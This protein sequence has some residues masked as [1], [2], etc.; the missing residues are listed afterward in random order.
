MSAEFTQTRDVLILGG[1][2]VGMTLAIGLAR[3]GATVHV[4]DRDDPAAQTAEG[5][6]G[7]ASAI[8]T[9]SW[10]L[11][12]HLGLAPLLE[13]RGSPIAAIAVNDAL[14]PG[15]IEFR[16]EPQEGSLGRMFANR[17]LR[18]ALFEAAAKEPNIAWTHRHQIAFHLHGG[19]AGK[20]PP[21]A[22]QCVVQ[23]RLH[24]QAPT[25]AQADLPAVRRAGAG[26]P[27][28]VDA[29]A[30][31]RPQRAAGIAK[32]IVQQH[33]GRDVL[34]AQHLAQKRHRA[35]ALGLD[36]GRHAQHKL[37]PQVGCQLALVGQ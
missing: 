28:V 20:Q 8:S 33:R 12:G 2:L 19:H 10:N 21:F 14:R 26:E 16:P 29:R 36:L 3:A 27:G 32:V 31:V 18:M 22:A 5:F 6:D 17:D 37:Q 7:R 25:V 30:Q 9:A 34:G 13:P 24:G 1:G 15:K 11:F 35:A 4:V 23:P